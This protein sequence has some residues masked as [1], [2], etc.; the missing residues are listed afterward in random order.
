MKKIDKDYKLVELSEL[1]F[2]KKYETDKRFECATLGIKTLDERFNTIIDNQN[3]IIKALLKV[4]ERQEEDERERQSNYRD[5]H[6][7]A[8]KELIRKAG[9]FRK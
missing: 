2:L 6:E 5:T 7:K 4:I 9:D 1:Q 8:M 3:E